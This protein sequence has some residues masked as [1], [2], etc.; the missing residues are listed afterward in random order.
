MNQH[1]IDQAEEYEK[2]AAGKE[3]HT[4][5]AYYL[6]AARDCR[7]MVKHT[8]KVKPVQLRENGKWVPAIVGTARSGTPG[9]YV[10][11]AA[12]LGSGIAGVNPSKVFTF[13]SEDAAMAFYEAGTKPSQYD[14]KQHMRLDVLNHPYND[15]YRLPSKA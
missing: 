14:L 4:E 12:M 1:L 3:D 13:A 5:E 8:Y 9:D 6:R 10:Q 2:I 7:R 15:L 11:D